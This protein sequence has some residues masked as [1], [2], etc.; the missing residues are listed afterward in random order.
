MATNWDQRSRQTCRRPRVV[1]TDAE[2]HVVAG[3]RL[4]AQFLHPDIEVVQ[5]DSGDAGVGPDS[6]SAD[7]IRFRDIAE[8]RPRP[9]TPEVEVPHYTAGA[10]QQLTLRQQEVLR[11]LIL[12]HTN[13]AIA[14]QLGI[15]P[16][17]VRIHVSAILRTLGVSSR[18][19]AATI[20]LDTLRGQHW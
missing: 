13:K 17:T 15:S 1:V 11:Q 18:A 10:L 8:A 7:T 14:R 4:L 16:A 20:G 2:P 9:D 3:I 5:S 12:G 6:H 19:A